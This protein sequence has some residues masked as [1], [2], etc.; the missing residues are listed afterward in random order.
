MKS[1]KMILSLTIICA[2][3]GI[4]LAKTY[5][6]TN[7]KIE[8]DKKAKVIENLS[9]VIDA[10]HFETSILDTL[11]YALDKNGDTLGIVFKS[12][13]SGFG[14][15]IEALVGLDIDSR[16]IGVKIATPG[17]GLQETPGLGV[18]VS[19][20]KFMDQFKGKVLEDIKITK[21]GGKIEA[22]TAATISSRGATDGIYDAVKR[23]EKYLPKKEVK[24][25]SEE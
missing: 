10:D 19:E 8:D 5:S 4:V 12:S 25:V 1:I 15:P 16:I 24:D 14:G 7:P 17:E 6:V 22:I 23:Y 20:P 18:K 2:V 3:A 9:K 11:W 13:G 21:D